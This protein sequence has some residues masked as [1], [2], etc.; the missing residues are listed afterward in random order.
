[1]LIL[2]IVGAAC[3][4]WVEFVVGSR[5]CSDRFFS[6]YSGFPLS[7]KA[8]ISKYQFDPEPEGHRFVSPRLLDV[9]L[10][11]QSWFINLFYLFTIRKDQK[12][13]SWELRLEYPH[14]SLSNIPYPYNFFPSVSRIP[15]IVPQYSVFPKPLRPLMG[16]RTSRP[17][18]LSLIRMA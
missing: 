17:S 1:M 3:H 15:I 16:P 13:K 11:K 4:M 18:V 10:V 8:N 6:R 7:S 5:P 9:T 2:I 12:Q 14:I